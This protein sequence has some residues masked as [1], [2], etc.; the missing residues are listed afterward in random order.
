MKKILILA[1]IFSLATNAMAQSGLSNMLG[2]LFGGKTDS[3]KTETTTNA[4]S[5]V[6]GALIG[7][8]LPVTNEML[9]GTWEYTSVACVLK[10]NDA[11]SNVGG[12]LGSSKIEET[13]N[14]YL[15]K[16]GVK[17]GS[18]YFTFANDSSCVFKVAGKDVK[19]KY[20]F[21]AQEKKLQLT[22][23]SRLN[24]T[25][26][27]AYNLNTVNIVFNADK[28][29]SLVKSVTSKV[30]GSSDGE[31]SKVSS[32]L[33]DSASSTLSTVS[34]LLEKYDGMMLGLKMKKQ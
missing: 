27:V 18:C 28:L 25:A 14:G 31:G 10:S 29:L 17:E 16:V 33:G 19:G 2:N 23:Y 26:D 20:N 7:N 12:A 30:A 1:V 21:N 11:L 13:L 3:S 24:M 22:F 6:L 5:N 15:A 9:I 4:V 8:S 34:S 32:L